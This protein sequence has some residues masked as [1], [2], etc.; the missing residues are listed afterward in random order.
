MR[1]IS[2]VLCGE[3]R[4]KRGYE[5]ALC[6]TVCYQWTAGGSLFVETFDNKAFDNEN[7]RKVARMKIGSE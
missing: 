6:S 5:Y 2:R 3:K 1:K 4:I 7:Q